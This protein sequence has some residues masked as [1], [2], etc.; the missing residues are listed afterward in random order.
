MA[1]VAQP[2]T[3]PAC[4]GEFLPNRK[5]P[6]LRVATQVYCSRQCA[7]GPRSARIP[8][9]DRPFRSVTVPGGTKNYVKVQ[10][11]GRA[12]NQCGQPYVPR[13]RRERNQ[14]CS[15]RCKDLARSARPDVRPCGWCREPFTPQRNDAVFCSSGCNQRARRAAL[16]GPRRAVKTKVAERDRWRCRICGGRVARWR[17][18][19]D[20]LSASVDHVV[21]VC[22]GGTNDLGNLRLAHLGCNMARG[23]WRKPSPRGRAV[24]RAA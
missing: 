13:N 1:R 8:I 10:P 22:E 7:A 5:N 12:C 14:F 6:R 15:R 18:F 24:R 19:P 20:P 11:G 21:L 23:G 17:R 4:D 3:C 9:A 2:S 16:G